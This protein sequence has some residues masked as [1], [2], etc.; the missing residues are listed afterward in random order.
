MTQHHAQHQIKRALNCSLLFAISA[1]I[2]CDRKPGDASPPAETPP[3]ES[4][5]PQT[6]TP[7]E[8]VQLML[9]KLGRRPS[10]SEALVEYCR[11][12]YEH[13]DAEVRAAVAGAMV[14]HYAGLLEEGDT[15]AKA[16]LDRAVKLLFDTH[17]ATPDQLGTAAGWVERSDQIE[18]ARELWAKI[19][20]RFLIS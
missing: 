18:L 11:S 7:I 19:A 14:K 16:E 17:S 13:P 3:V 10:E 5:E 4:A 1:L 6:P 12:R 2:G 20:K 15:A 9:W 8:E